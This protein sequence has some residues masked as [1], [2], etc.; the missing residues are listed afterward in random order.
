MNVIT[1]FNRERDVHLVLH[2]ISTEEKKAAG[3]ELKWN[4]NRDPTQKV[5]TPHKLHRKS[6]ILSRSII[7]T[8]IS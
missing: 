8:N 3:L 7:V 5:C 2:G 4:A 6:I 1:V